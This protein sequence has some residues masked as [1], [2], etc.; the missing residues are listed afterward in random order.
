MSTRKVAFR[1]EVSFGTKYRKMRRRSFNAVSLSGRMT[2]LKD[3]ENLRGAGVAPG[4]RSKDQMAA[5]ID[6]VSAAGERNMVQL[7]QQ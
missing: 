1:K 2:R 7:L 4:S 5:V 6:G 3:K